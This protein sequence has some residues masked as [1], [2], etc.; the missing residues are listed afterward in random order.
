MKERYRC[1]RCGRDKFEKPTPHNC[2]SQYLKHYGKLKYKEQF[3][4][5]MFEKIEETHV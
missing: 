1:K 5:N 2:G 3:N 4:G